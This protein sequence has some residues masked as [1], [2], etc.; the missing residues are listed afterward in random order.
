MLKFEIKVPSNIDK[1]EEKL[2]TYYQII[3]VKKKENRLL[4]KEKDILL[5]KYLG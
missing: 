1:L 4:K 5:K 2:N 3:E